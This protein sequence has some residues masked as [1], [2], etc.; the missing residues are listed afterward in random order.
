MERA[1]WDRVAVLHAIQNAWSAGNLAPYDAIAIAQVLDDDLGG[2]IRHF[3]DETLLS[4][5]PEEDRIEYSQA[6]LSIL[7]SL[8]LVGELTFSSRS[9]HPVLAK[10]FAQALRQMDQLHQV[11]LRHMGATLSV[12]SVCSC[13]GSWPHLELLRMSDFESG[14]EYAMYDSR[15]IC[16]SYFYR[17]KWAASDDEEVSFPLSPHSL[18]LRNLS[19]N[20]KGTKA[21]LFACVLDPAWWEYPRIPAPLPD[22]VILLEPL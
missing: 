5:R 14:E 20:C 1:N 21:S 4:S 3:S 6:I 10:E 15:L 2:A 9:I 8:T 17:R 19:Q 16:N 11:T 18:H 13:I 22:D 12:R 7:H